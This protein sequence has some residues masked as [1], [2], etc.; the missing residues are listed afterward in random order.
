EGSAVGAHRRG[1]VSFPPAEPPARSPPGPASSEGIGAAM[2]FILRR[3]VFYLVAAWVALTINFFIPRA[4]PGNAVQ[5]VMA[6][7][8]QPAAVRLQGAAGDARCRP[9]R[10]PVGPV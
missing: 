6:K 4:M 5:S 1:A 8:P 9:P 7:F 3:L 2:S 10:F